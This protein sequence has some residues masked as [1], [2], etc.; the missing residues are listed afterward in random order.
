[1]RRYRWVCP[2]CGAA[3]LGGARPRAEAVVRFC[4]PCSKRTGYLVRTASPVLAARSCA[5]AAKAK[6]KRQKKKAKADEK[7]IRAGR[8]TRKEVARCARA[9][10]IAA[11]DLS[12]RA[13]RDAHTTGRSYGGRVVL[14][15][16]AAATL[17]ETLALI[18]HEVAHE[19][20]P[21]DGHGQ[22]WRAKFLELARKVYGVDPGDPGGSSHT[23]HDHIEAALGG[24]GEVS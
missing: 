21:W 1:M 14:S 15:L 20:C 17:G 23:L 13:R 6:A 24:V 19:A 9:A 3:K 7:W 12:I 22:R 11:P 8:D 5:K 16:P 4:L 10:R 18:C 2:D